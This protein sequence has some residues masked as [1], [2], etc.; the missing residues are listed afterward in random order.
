MLKFVVNLFMLFI[1]LLF[2]EC[3]VVVVWV[4]FE[5]V[6]FLFFYEYVVGE[7]R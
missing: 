5:V 7:I 6:E 3:F 1:E 2:L 4:G